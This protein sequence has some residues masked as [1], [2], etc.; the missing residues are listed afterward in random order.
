MRKDGSADCEGVFSIHV[1][2]NSIVKCG[3]YQVKKC[4][5]SQKAGSIVNAFELYAPENKL[6]NMSMKLDVFILGR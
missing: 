2:K 6:L 1:M 5:V 4:Y 3:E